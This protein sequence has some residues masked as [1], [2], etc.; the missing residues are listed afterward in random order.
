MKL[1]HRADRVSRL[2]MNSHG[3]RVALEILLFRFPGDHGFSNEIATSRGPRFQI[4]H[5]I[6]RFPSLWD[7]KE[8]AEVCSKCHHVSPSVV[9][10]P[11]SVCQVAA[12]WP[13]RHFNV[14]AATWQPLGGRAEVLRRPRKSVMEVEPRHQSDARRCRGGHRSGA[15]TRADTGQTQTSV[16]A[17]TVQCRG[18]VL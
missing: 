16:R 11:P 2:C 5:A 14:A 15:A 9:K 13:P 8:N 7:S 1:Q 17:D 3:S 4:L 10:C 6:P 18:S 12:K